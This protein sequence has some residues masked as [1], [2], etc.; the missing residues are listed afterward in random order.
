MS[1]SQNSSEEEIR[2]LSKEEADQIRAKHP[3]FG[4]WRVV[5]WQVWVVLIAALVALILGQTLTVV[6]SVVWG[7]LCVVVPGAVFARAIT[8]QM[9]RHSSSDGVLVGVFAWEVVKVVLTVVM[10]LVAPRVVFGLSWLALLAGFVVTM[11]AYWVVCYWLIK[12]GHSVR[13]K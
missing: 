13:T 6:Y 3:S 12:N 11:K 5:G 8:R 4:P 2:V 7:G 9:Q 10:L 1:D